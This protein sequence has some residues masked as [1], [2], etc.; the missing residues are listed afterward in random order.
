MEDFHDTSGNEIIISTIHKAKGRE[1]DNVF[2]LVD[3]RQQLT[4]ERLRCFYVAMTRARLNLSIHT[5]GTAFNSITSA[6]HVADTRSYGMPT[7]IVIQ[8]SHKDVNLSFF[9]H[10]HN[11]VLT[12]QSGDPL[13]C[14]DNTLH[15]P[16][17]K[18]VAEYSAAMRER[19]AKLKKMGYVPTAATTRFIVAWKRK[20]APKEEKETAV[21]LADLKLVRQQ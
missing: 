12:L 1:F 4:D 13:T 2:M 15:T 8:M 18:I 5:N 9:Q 14:D 21:L 7:E 17:G 10:C 3:G 20:D 11:D 16:S 6:T 19:I